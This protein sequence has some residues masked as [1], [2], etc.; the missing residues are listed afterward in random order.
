MIKVRKATLALA[1]AVTLGAASLAACG[2]N[3]SGSGGAA[4]LVVWDPIATYGESPEQDKA[5]R[6]MLAEI[7][8][9]FVAKHPGAEIEHKSFGYDGYPQRIASAVAANAAPDIAWDWGDTN[10]QITEPLNDRLS[11]QQKSDLTLLEQT[12][13]SA[14]DGKIHVLPWGTYQGV[15]VYNKKLFAQAGVEVPTTQAAFLTA[16]D[17][18]NGKGIVPSKVSFGA[19]NWFN[20]LDALYAGQLI[21]DISQWNRQGIPYTGPE[22]KA[23]TVELMKTFDHKCWG[24]HPE[25]KGTP[26][27]HEQ[28][29]MSGKSAM[30][31]ARSSVPLAEARKA[32]GKDNVGV[33]LQPALPGGKPNMDASLAQGMSIMSS[34]KQKDLA[35]QYISFYTDVDQQEL[36]WQT[37]QQLPNNTK[38]KVTSTDPVLRQLLA[39]AVDPQ[40]QV[41]AWPVNPDESQAYARMTPDVVTGRLAVDDFLSKMQVVRTKTK[42]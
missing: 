36:A 14:K 42:G 13:T 40:F 5:W 29:F 12:V 31:Y 3:S 1:V 2:G 6:G 22:Y 19:P 8:K 9:R 20:R 26:G 37:V 23:A 16:C 35:W 4:K 30:L 38:V 18:L 21:G 25:S 10:W 41:G 17:A 27:D 34:S 28:S 11:A 7:D 32:L 24:D 33:F 15:W 39:W